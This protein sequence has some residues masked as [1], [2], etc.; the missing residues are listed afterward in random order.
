MAAWIP[1][2]TRVKNEVVWWLA[3]VAGAAHIVVTQ[4]E[5]AGFDDVSDGYGFL[6]V[7]VGFVQRMNAYGKESVAEIIEHYDNA[8]E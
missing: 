5:E 1:A 7:L 2:F 4:I 6:V 3:F 8:A